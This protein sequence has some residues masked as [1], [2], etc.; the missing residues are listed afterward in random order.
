M[1]WFLSS[2]VVFFV[3]SVA[4]AQE[5]ADTLAVDAL[6]PI[7][8]QTGEVL[9]AASTGSW[10]GIASAVV[11]LLMTLAKSPMFGAILERV[12][13]QWMYVIMVVLSTASGL[14][15]HY[16]GSSPVAEAVAIG[17]GTAGGSV[18]LH[19]T[20]KNASRLAGRK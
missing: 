5:A 7:I 19:T 18:L 17:V 14:L 1:R 6:T 11:M 16:A 10:I 12:P 8:D 9:N 2:L 15:S 4:L 20:K 13:P 3:G